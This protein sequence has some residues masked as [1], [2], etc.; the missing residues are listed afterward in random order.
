MAAP[1]SLKSTSDDRSASVVDGKLHFSFEERPLSLVLHESGVKVEHLPGTFARTRSR[2]TRLTSLSQAQPHVRCMPV[3]SVDALKNVPT[4]EAASPSPSHVPYLHVLSSTFDPDTSRFALALLH[5]VES[6]LKLWS[7][8][9]RAEQED[10]IDVEEWASKLHSRA[11]KGMFL[12]RR[13]GRQL[14]RPRCTATCRHHPLQ[15]SPRPDQSSRRQGNG[16]YD[17]GGA[18]QA[19]P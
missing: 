7:V 11:Y 12:R 10:A 14:I 4:A 6:V 8:S 18:C 3:F 17:L 15:T 16:K 1:T 9:C 13:S 2:T 19:S 5:P